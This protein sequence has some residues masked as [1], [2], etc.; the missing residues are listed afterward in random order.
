MFKFAGNSL[1][2]LPLYLY[3]TQIFN[4]SIPVSTSSEFKERSV[5]PLTRRAWRTTTL[6]NQPTRRGRPVVVPYSR[7]T[8]RIWSPTSSFN[9][10][11]NGP[12]PTRVV[13][14]FETPTTVDIFDGPTPE[15]IVTPPATGFEDVTNGYDP[16]LMSNITPCSAANTTRRPTS[17]A[18][19]NTTDVSQTYFAIR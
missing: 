14:A 13:Y 7:P 16:C 1:I 10:V 6:S 5:I 19:F 3:E 15:P 2:L 9:S 11:A 8:S 18:S 17:S 12:S 4:V